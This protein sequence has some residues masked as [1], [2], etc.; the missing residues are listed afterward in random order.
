MVDRRIYLATPTWN[1]RSETYRRAHLA[2]TELDADITDVRGLYAGNRD[3]LVR[4]PV[5]LERYTEIW[6]VTDQAGWIGKGV[7]TEYADLTA[8]GCPAWW[9]N[10][11]T[12]DFELGPIT[13]RWQRWCQLRPP[14][15]RRRPR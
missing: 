2:M 9:W 15:P 4:W 14:K 6:I 11:Q 7:A 12:R 8:R 1:Y 13:G 5:E 10:R 3:W